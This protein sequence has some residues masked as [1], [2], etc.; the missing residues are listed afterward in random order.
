MLAREAET[1]PHRSCD[2]KR[3]PAFQV[4]DLTFR[5]QRRLMAA[6]MGSKS[7]MRKFEPAIEFQVRHFLLRAMNEPD[8]LLAN[9]QK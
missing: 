7:S 3:L 6:Q 2:Y 5:Q 4:N 8:N 1:D 9:L